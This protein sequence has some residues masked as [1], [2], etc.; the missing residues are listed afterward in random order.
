MSGLDREASLVKRLKARDEQAVLDLFNQYG[1]LV[2]V[3][4]QR[5]VGDAGVAE[6]I[7]QDSFI[8][9]WRNIDS[10]D[11]E[12]NG[13][14]RVW[15]TNIARNLAIDYLRKQQIAT[16]PQPQ[17]TR[18]G[19]QT[20]LNARMKDQNGQRYEI[21]WTTEAAKHV[22]ENYVKDSNG[23]VHQGIDHT[24]ISK[25]LKTAR[26]VVAL[27]EDPRPLYHICLTGYKGKVYETYVYLVPELDHRPPRCVIVSSYV[28]NKQH[29]RD[30]FNN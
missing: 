3:T 2:Y 27:H 9:L 1:H 5:V 8:K 24:L 23:G 6:D 4:I 13:R 15:A 11:L 26:F 17:V 7:L 20:H 25:L 22:L 21:Y 16:Q 19:E 29:Y 30:L 14:L 10:Y 12:R 18:Q 28:S